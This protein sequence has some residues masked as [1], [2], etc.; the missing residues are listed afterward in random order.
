MASAASL[1]EQDSITV[2]TEGGGAGPGLGNANSP[3]QYDRTSIAKG[4]SGSLNMAQG[5]LNLFRKTML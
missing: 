2:I 1:K 4:D 3:A 5:K